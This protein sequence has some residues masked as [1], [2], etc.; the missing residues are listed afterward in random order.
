[1]SDISTQD[2]QTSNEIIEFKPLSKAA[3]SVARAIF[4]PNDFIPINGRYEATRDAML[5]LLTS[6]PIGYNLEL[7]NKALTKEYASITV[8]LSVKFHSTGIER[9]AES[10]GTCEMSEVKAAKTLHNLI[11]RA[12]TRAIKRAVETV[13]G[14]VINALILELRGGFEVGQNYTTYK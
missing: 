14:A 6:L 7:T 13:F 12:E 4:T 11:T 3:L 10:T 2:S 5:K 8:K 9:Q 1:M